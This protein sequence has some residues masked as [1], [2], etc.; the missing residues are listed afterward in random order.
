MLKKNIVKRE[1]YI[2]KEKAGAKE[3]QVITD[4]KTGEVL[5]EHWIEKRKKPSGRPPGGK[6]HSFYRVYCKN[7]S[8]IIDRKHL[9]LTEVGVLMSLMRFVDWESNFLVHPRTG[10]NANASEL[11]QMLKIDRADLLKYLD[12]LHTK[13]MLSVVKIGG[14][15]YP[16]HYILNSHILFK[17]NKMK[18]INEHYRFDKDCPY[19]PPS[20]IKYKQRDGNEVKNEFLD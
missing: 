9:T 2:G 5:S 17:G 3:Y 11:A 15:G 10:R 6:K 4:V 12:R 20:P 19:E 7:W 1:V 14:N 13:G 16:N 18:D 8:D